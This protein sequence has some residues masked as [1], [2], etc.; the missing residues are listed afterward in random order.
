MLSALKASNYDCFLL[1]GSK[2][3][4]HCRRY[5]GP[6]MFGR[7]SRKWSFYLRVYFCVNHVTGFLLSQSMQYIQ[8]HS[9]M[10]SFWWRV[11]RDT[12]RH[13]HFFL[14]IASIAFCL[15][16]NWQRFSAELTVEFFRESW[17]RFPVPHL[18]KKFNIWEPGPDKTQ[19]CAIIFNR[20]LKIM[21]MM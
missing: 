11:L 10:S 14:Y 15:S 9:S 2:V 8:W 17:K 20:M 1:H 7:L 21:F 6:C 16:I 12:Q 5:F 4:S 18:S 19:S 13:R 3:A